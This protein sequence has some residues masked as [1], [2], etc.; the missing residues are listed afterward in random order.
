MDATGSCI[1]IGGGLAGLSTALALAPMPVILISKAPLGFEASSVLAQ[2]G[3]AAS[4][5]P[6]DGLALHLS[7]TLKAG[8][9]LCDPAVA[10]AIL[11]AAPAAIENLAKLGAPFDRDAGG[12][13]LLGLEAA[14]SRRRIVHAGGD[15]AGA[16]SCGR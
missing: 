14:H 6:D 2:G 8:D 13:L 4:L 12:R 3:I 16:K 15:L 1:I 9:G 5:G 10:H 7:D 11:A